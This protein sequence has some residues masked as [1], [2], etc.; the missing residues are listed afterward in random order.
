MTGPVDI[1]AG[2]ERQP[3]VLWGIPVQQDGGKGGSR[4]KY[5]N[6]KIF[7]PMRWSKNCS[8]MCKVAIYISQLT[9]RR[10]SDGRSFW[11]STGITATELPNRRGV[12]KTEAP[13]KRWR[14]NISCLYRPF[15]KSSIRNEQAGAAEMQLLLLCCIQIAS[16]SSGG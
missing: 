9:R 15:A 6:A 11:L 1:G 14:K 16:V 4:M 12:F 10:K 2:A 8:V 13:W 5:I 7:F 3:Q